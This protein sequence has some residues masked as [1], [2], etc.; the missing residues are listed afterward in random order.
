MLVVGGS[1]GGTS[2]D[3]AEV[4]DPASGTW[5]AAGS[6][7]AGRTGHTATVL[8]D[9]TVLVV[10]GWSDPDTVQPVASTERFDPREGTWVAGPPL[11]DARTAHTAALLADG[12]VM[13]A[14]GS[15]YNG[16]NG[17]PIASVEVLRPGAA[18]WIMAAPMLEARAAHTATVLPDGDILVV[19]GIGS[20]TDETGPM[21]TTLASAEIWEPS[22]AVWTAT[23][24]LDDGRAK[25]A[26]T[27]LLD[28]TVL[29]SRMGQ[30]GTAV[31]YDPSSGTFAP[32]DDMQHAR[33]GS[34]STRLESGEV[35]VVGG[36]G[37]DELETGRSAEVYDPVTASWS[38]TV[39]MADARSGHTAT[40]LADGVVLVVGGQN[41]GGELVDPSEM[42]FP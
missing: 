14:G 37:P 24:G 4:Y 34:T 2:I 15:T 30:Q 25:H 20:E 18:S 1:S 10:G 26:A 29:V 32:T 42:Y 16:G 33:F 11:H 7:D 9:G 21:N 12:S 19:G 17:A 5:A 8:P 41:P 40:R 3:E 23:S 22:D 35:L 13:V 38:P 39:A 27:M 28:G 36:Y 6:L 31:I